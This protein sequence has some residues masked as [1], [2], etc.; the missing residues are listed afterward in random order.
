VVV[1]GRAVRGWGAL[2]ALAACGTDVATDDATA[3][4]C[5]GV[6]DGLFLTDD[7]EAAPEEGFLAYVGE[8]LRFGV[9]VV[10]GVAVR[11]SMGDGG[12]V[13]TTGGATAQDYTWAAP[14]HYVMTFEACG[15]SATRPVT[16]TVRAAPG[17]RAL[18]GPLLVEPD[19]AFLVAL[20]DFDQLAIS[21]AGGSIRHVAVCER[22]TA[23]VRHDDGVAVLCG[24]DAPAVE[25]YAA[26][27]ATRRWR[28]DLADRG[29]VPT[30]L[31]RD[32]DALRVTAR[33][34]DRDEGILLLV[35]DGDLV[36][37]DPLPADPGV[38]APLP[39]G[40]ALLTRWRSRGGEARWWVGA[41][42]ALAET[43]A[44]ALAPVLGADSDT[45]SR[46]VAT[47]LGAVAVRPDGAT[48]LIGGLRAN[49]IGGLFRDGTA[50]GD[51]NTVRADLRLVRLDDA[52]GTEIARARLDDRDLVRA[53]AWHPRGDWVFAASLGQRSVDWL[54]AFDLSPVDAR[55]G[56]GE[57]VRA[58]AVAPAWRP[59]SAVSEAPTVHGVGGALV[60]YGE[61]SRTVVF[62]PLE[63]TS[64]GAPLPAIDLTP[65][66]GEVLD[67]DVLA[68][69]RL[70]HD[71][72]DRRMSSV[73]YVSC[74]S[75]HLDGFDDG[76]VWDFTNR[77]E[78]LRRTIPLHGLAARDG[79]PLHWSANFD[80]LQD[81]E[82]DIRLH[83]GGRGYMADADWEGAAGPSLGAPKA[84]LSSELD[85]LAAY[86][87]SLEAPAARWQPDA[88]DATR[89]A[90]GEA[91]YL[92]RGCA[93]CHGVEGDISQGRSGWTAPGVPDLVDV[94]T[95]TAA[96]GQRLG[97]TLVGFDPPDLRDVW[98]RPPYLHDGRAATLLDVLADNP[99]DLHG[100]TSDLTPAQLA[101][102]E[103]YLRSL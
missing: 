74:A 63:G 95:R 92:T 40:G 79:L 68:G 46:G 72:S 10:A 53:V 15:L 60:V 5:A 7:A 23:L 12:I 8:P 26:D 67:A 52:A 100:Q 32:G 9:P 42:A 80:E 85:Q 65:P 6:Q 55:F 29:L 98:D 82:A 17:A 71:A 36:G 84:T 20:A 14:G 86:M 64:F 103:L 57:G 4:A 39:D 91:L 73:G 33:R 75:C 78:G 49:V 41:P 99:G 44:R 93:D 51:D 34:R 87:R 43:P 25:L 94:G 28:L 2:L 11:V 56:V 31:S 38:L 19:G 76:Q 54:D 45:V 83:Q 48:A 97:G 21:A 70:F 1:S 35:E 58:L 69:A 61:L 89:L 47:Y 62:V 27:L 30:S 3:D 59:A 90:A 101:D 22:P 50:L 77:G 81:F 88:A 37:E 66:E 24:G 16:V 96:S 13:E 18:G 102:L